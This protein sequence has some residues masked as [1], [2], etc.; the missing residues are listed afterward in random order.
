MHLQMRFKCSIRITYLMF[1]LF[2][3]SNVENI[4]EV[5]VQQAMEGLY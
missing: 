2:L 4:E 1:C 5:P 3:V